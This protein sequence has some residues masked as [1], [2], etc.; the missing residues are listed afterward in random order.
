MLGPTRNIGRSHAAISAHL[1]SP[2]A[3]ERMFSG[4]LV[5]IVTPMD[6]AGALDFEAWDRL[7]DLHL[8]AGTSGIVVGGTTGESTALA[9][10][11]LIELLRRAR[12]HLRGRASLI[13]GLGGSHTAS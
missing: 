5:A 6:A 3:Q 11:E 2:E 12:T 1:R 7:L 13:A 9:E 8:R 4:S 10:H